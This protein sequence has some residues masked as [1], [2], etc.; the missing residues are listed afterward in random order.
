MRIALVY[1]EPL[2]S[3]YH[4]LGE[5]IAVASVLESVTAVEGALQAKGHVVERLGLQPPVSSAIKSLESLEAEL[6]FNL[7]E[8]F[9]GRPQTEWVV[10]GALSLRGRPFTGAGPLTLALCLN[11]AWAKELLAAHGIPTAPFQLLHPGNLAEFALGF[12]VIVKPLQ[13]DGSHGLSAASVVHHLQA[14]ANQVRSVTD[15]Y[16]SPALV[17]T[18]L[19]GREFNAA[20]LGSRSPRLLPVSEMVYSK[21]MPY[22]RILTYQAKWHY[23]TLDFQASTATCPAP[24]SEAMRQEIGQKALAAHRALGAPPYARVDLRADSQGKLHVLEV[25]PNPDLSLETGIALQAI[26]AGMKYE[27]LIQEIMDLALEEQPPL[28]PSFAKGEGKGKGASRAAPGVSLRHVGPQDVSEL[29][30]ITQDTGFFRPDEVAGAQEVLEECVAKGGDSGYYVYVAEEARSSKFETRNPDLLGWVC[31]GPTPLTL[32]TWDLY[33]IA[34]APGHQDQGV[35]TRLI[36]LAE[37]EIGR[38]GGRQVLVETSSQELYAPTRR[39]YCT[40]GY[41]E[42]GRIPD[43]YDLGDAKVIFAKAVSRGGEPP[44]PP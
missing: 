15:W 26:A 8:G 27:E 40:K 44:M 13:E 42:V 36:R 19:P 25:N 1:N 30:R 20:V 29:V 43:F 35:G 24:V 34:V 37:T 33:W 38:R 41:R 12:P 23:Q 28:P 11:K 4:T 2:P 14:L 18:F 32:G 17:E 16:G 10:A 3:R 6:V 9:D 5:D 39:F 21:D 31:F 7:F 22:P